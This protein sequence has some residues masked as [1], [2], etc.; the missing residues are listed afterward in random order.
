MKAKP[1]AIL[2][3]LLLAVFLTGS[4]TALAE[5][6]PEDPPKEDAEDAKEDAKE[7]PKKD[8]EK[9]PEDGKKDEEDPDDAPKGPSPTNDNLTN[10]VVQHWGAAAEQV[11]KGS[12]SMPRTYG[13]RLSYNF[14]KKRQ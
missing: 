13:V 12:F 7:E 10:T 5:D 6:P 2:I 14:S 1:F 3:C 8:G 4:G 11:A 9:E